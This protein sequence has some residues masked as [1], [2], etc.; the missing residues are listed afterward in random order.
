M[1]SEYLHHQRLIQECPQNVWL[2]RQLVLHEQQHFLCSRKQLQGGQG[3][4]MGLTLVLRLDNFFV[5]IHPRGHSPQYEAAVTKSAILL[6]WS[7][8]DWYHLGLQLN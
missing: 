6:A 2:W 3:T 1:A 8:L 5:A 4:L 7:L